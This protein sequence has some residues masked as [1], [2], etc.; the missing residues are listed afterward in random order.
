MHELVD[1]LVGWAKANPGLFWSTVSVGFYHVI[2]AAIGSL[3]MPDEKSG[4]F[5]R[6]FFKFSN[7]LAA[8]YARAGAS[9][10]ESKN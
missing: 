10:P 8:N 5:Y 2:G 4:K 1:Y 9:K 6:W 3:E 7:R